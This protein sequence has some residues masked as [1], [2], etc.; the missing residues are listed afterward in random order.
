M[1]HVYRCHLRWSDMD[2]YGIINNVVYLRLLE[3]ARV[4][5]IFRLAPANGDVLFRGGSVVVRQEI[6]YKRPLTHRHQPVDIEMW[7]TGLDSATVTIAY[8]VKDDGKV[9]AIAS[10]TLAPFDYAKSR[11]RRLTDAETEF[12]ERYLEVDHATAAY[13]SHR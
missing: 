1:P 10:S 5:L 7:V 4:D 9:C 12:F 6:S 2:I 8:E 3:E 11:P 13:R